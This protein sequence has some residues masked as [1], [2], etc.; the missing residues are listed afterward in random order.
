VSA[1]NAD[2][3][4]L[5][6]AGRPTRDAY[7]ALTLLHNAS[8]EGLDPADYQSGLLDSLAAALAQ[9]APAGAALRFDGML[10]ASMVRYMRDLHSGRVDPRSAGFRM[11]APPDHHDF[12]S[13]LRDAVAHHRVRQAAEELAPPFVLYRALRD[14]LTRYRS[15]AADPALGRFPLPNRTLQPGDESAGVPELRRL[16]G[17]LGDLTGDAVE[18][19]EAAVY[20][21]PLAA[22]VR[23]FQTRH[24]I[25]ADGI[26]GPQTRAALQVPLAARV[27]Q[28]ELALERLR[29]L[30]HPGDT[31]FVTV[32]IPMFHLWAWDSRPAR[33]P[34]LDMDVIVGR[35]L[36]T[37]TPVFVEEMRSVIFRPYW[38]VPASIAR[39]EIV[40]RIERD[41]AYL[42]RQ[43]ME[44]VAGPGD[45]AR[46][47][48]LT[49]DA[50]E[51]L[52]R[53]V[54]RVRQRPG[55]NNALGLVKFV[56]PND[57]N[58]YM[59]GTPAMDLFSRSR[60]DFSHGCVRV[61]DPFALAEW[62]LKDR[63]EWTRERIVAATEG[64]GP[65][66][67]DLPRP[68]QVILFYVTAAVMPEDGT[69]RFADD[70]YRHDVRLENALAR[71]TAGR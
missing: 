53:G 59:H 60:R 12:D 70:I 61:A 54:L 11:P 37:Q 56:F 27:R 28:I 21:A 23:R 17:A 67:V 13:L 49:A 4:W 50:V 2:R 19:A 30:P 32:N 48:P 35:A 10:T 47:E 55:P 39:H 1:G 31:R 57:E 41:P 16:L 33:T 52:K 3:T 14:A 6:A 40:P 62:V 29:W 24:G 7:E 18:P 5:D 22:A 43:G 63:P 26:V 51:R 69:V 20:D 36:N 38:N 64:R 44:L 71:R 58:I 42:A 15:L 9:A 45:D 34:S 46:V 8:A 25:D 65:V 68:I 66:R